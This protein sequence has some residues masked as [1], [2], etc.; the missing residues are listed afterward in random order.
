[1]NLHFRCKLAAMSSIVATAISHIGLT[2]IAKKFDL[3]PSAIQK[4][5]D[6]GFLPESDL[7]GRTKY[8]HGI[9]ELSEGR[10]KAEEMLA[11]TRAAWQARAKQA[12]A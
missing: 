2:P 12:V 4:W 1:V 8:A 9:E 10:Y 3:W 5:R 7:S 11:E 6:Q